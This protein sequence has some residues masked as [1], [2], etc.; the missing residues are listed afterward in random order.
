LTDESLFGFA[1][2]VLEKGGPVAFTVVV[3]VIG[4]SLLL[5]KLGW[6]RA[7]GTEAQMTEALK[8]L[9]AEMQRNHSVAEEHREEIRKAVSGHA[10]RIA[11]IEGQITASDRR[12]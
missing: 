4:F 10:E 2:Q 7:S 12:R 9:R 6:P 5:A 11:R 3:V 1:L 8:E